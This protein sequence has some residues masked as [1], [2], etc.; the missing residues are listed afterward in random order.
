[1][2]VKRE[3]AINEGQTKQKSVEFDAKNAEFQRNNKERESK[4]KQL[5][6]EWC[7]FGINHFKALVR[8]LNWLLN[9]N[10]MNIDTFFLNYKS[11]TNQNKQLYRQSA[12]RVTELFLMPETTVLVEDVRKNVYFNPIF[13]RFLLL[14][15]RMIKDF[16]NNLKLAKNFWSWFVQR[17][18]L[19]F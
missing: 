12:E 6:K 10:E 16:W 7:Q 8:V 3:Q 4:G 14:I 11:K 17:V 19:S 1:M 9:Q 15:T 18:F 5:N 13:L 2:R